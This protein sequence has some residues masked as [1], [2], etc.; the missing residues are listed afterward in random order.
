[1]GFMLSDPAVVLRR[2]LAAQNAHDLD[3]FVAC[4][5]DDYRSEQPDHPGREFT[6]SD[7]VRRNWGAIFDAVPD[8]RAEL[9]RS[10]V[11]G[12]TVWSEWDWAGTRAD[13]PLHM[14]GVIIMGVRDDRIAWGRLYISDVQDTGETID[15][16]I[17]QMTGG[18]G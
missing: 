2:L 14:R 7:Q 1:M 8:F 13:G 18:G 3:A 17:R 4:F 12:D 16:D 15:E 6:G 10:A 9:V 5:A 11:D